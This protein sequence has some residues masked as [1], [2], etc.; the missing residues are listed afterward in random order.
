MKR[1]VKLETES[2]AGWLE[3]RSSS[4]NQN[5]LNVDAGRKTDKGVGQKVGK[6]AAQGEM[7]K[8]RDERFWQKTRKPEKKDHIWMLTKQ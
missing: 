5:D 8:Q 4:Q 6:L 3:M 7:G 2:N 1:R